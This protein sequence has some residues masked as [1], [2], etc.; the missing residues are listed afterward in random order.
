MVFNVISSPNDL[1][2]RSVKIIA[3]PNHNYQIFINLIGIGLA[4]DPFTHI[5]I[6]SQLPMN[7]L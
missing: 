7:Y 2:R 3:S 1:H 6:I 5:R 4:I